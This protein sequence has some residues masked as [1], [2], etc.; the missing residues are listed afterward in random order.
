MH[1]TYRFLFSIICACGACAT[2]EASALIDCLA[3][4]TN[5]TC[6]RG[7]NDLVADINL[8]S[9]LDEDAAADTRLHC[10]S[11]NFMMIEFNPEAYIVEQ[12]ASEYDWNPAQAIK[13]TPATFRNLTAGTKY[14]FRFYR[15]RKEGISRP[16]TSDWFSTYEADY[17]PLAV[18]NLSVL[19]YR[20]EDENAYQLQ[21]EVGFEPAKDRSCSYEVVKWDG[22]LSV[23][24]SCES[25]LPQFQFELYKLDFGKS[26]NITI[27]SYNENSIKASPKKFTMFYAPTCLEYYGSMAICAPEQVEGLR[28]EY[29]Y[30][31]GGFCNLQVSWD[32]PAQEPDNYTVE[33]FS[34]ENYPVVKCVSGNRTEVS[35]SNVKL[36]SEYDVRIRAHSVGGNSVT[37]EITQNIA[38]GA[39]MK[40]S[41]WEITVS[42][43]ASITLAVLVGMIYLHY[44]KQRSNHFTMECSRFESLNRK[45]SPA[46]TIMKLL[47]KECETE[48]G[49]NPLLHDKF[50]LCPQLLKLGG[51]LGSGAYGIVKMGTLQDKLGSSTDVA[52]KMLKPNPSTED[53]QNFHKEILIMKCAGQHPNIVSLIGCC[54]L[55]NK[56]VLVVEYCCKGDLQTY[57]R[58]IWQ[59]MV[60]VAFNHR[61]RLKFDADSFITGGIQY[62]PDD[63]GGKEQN[64]Q[65]VHVI[66]N[67]L[68]DI[69]Q[70][71]AHCTETVTANDL[72][73]FARQ[74]ATG[75]EFLSSNRIIHRDL[76]ARNVLVCADRIVKI[77]DF[78]L[79]RD[80]YQE[81]LYKKQGNGKL[82]VKWMAIEAL[83][84]QI[85]TTYSDVWSFGILLWEIITMGAIPYPGISTNVIL[86]LV[87]SGY[88]MERPPSCGVELYDIMYSCWHV[89]SQSRP[90]FTRLKESLDKLLSCQSDAT[91]LNMDEILCCDQDYQRVLEE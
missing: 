74:T 1:V 90:T 19:N 53:V 50:K 81:N 21:I 68:Y 37:A 62:L 88:R 51:V 7:C 17:E 71:L 35:F 12:S 66:N 76:A 46:E 8:Y 65:N 26:Y 28:V 2:H 73:N 16:E 70:D 58:R 11:Q 59:N 86:K 30:C 47:Q 78:G 13:G 39:S 54:I 79:S 32:K 84:H 72:L 69:Q 41:H 57:L 55:Y 89:R 61:A 75:M 22:Q 3:P 56:P 36:E 20:A 5:E 45:D 29:I 23:M 27:S 42:I 43:T 4:C 91:Y 63:S 15:L 18:Q 82:P 6:V 49:A 67:C 38:S 87:K 24:E 83:T 33:V 34:P 85:Y 31:Y 52:V 25:E 64:Y 60:N 80:I 77:S 44:Y 14:R 40:K 10:T 48:I 9:H